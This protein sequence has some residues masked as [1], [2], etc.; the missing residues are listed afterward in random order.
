MTCLH[1]SSWL[2]WLTFNKFYKNKSLLVGRTLN[3][4]IYLLIDL[5]SSVYPKILIESNESHMA[6]TCYTIFIGTSW[7]CV[8]RPDAVSLEVC[9]GW[10]SSGSCCAYSFHWSSHSSSSGCSPNGFIPWR[11][12]D[13]QA[14]RTVNS[15]THSSQIHLVVKHQ[16][17]LYCYCRH[18]PFLY[19]NF[20]KYNSSA[21]FS[22]F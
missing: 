18:C 22:M 3:M 4:L 1:V 2:I 12:M 9:C 6:G 10:C 21:Y 7:G 14:Y 17:C 20:L 13:D 16:R 19:T 15:F 8:R 11:R 5:F